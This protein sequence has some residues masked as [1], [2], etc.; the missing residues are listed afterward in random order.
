MN[1]KF[2]KI[3]ENNNAQFPDENEDDE[4]DDKFNDNEENSEGK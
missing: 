2:T 1:E 3:L 4:E